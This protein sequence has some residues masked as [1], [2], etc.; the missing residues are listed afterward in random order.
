MR[1]E[2]PISF[3]KLVS[4]RSPSVPDVSLA[5]GTHLAAS[6]IYHLLLSALFFFLFSFPEVFFFGGGC[7]VGVFLVIGFVLLFLVF[8]ISSKQSEVWFF[9]QPLPTQESGS[10]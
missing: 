5:N 7:L 2:I 4:H 8:F 1:S 10:L 6:C 3:M 9:L